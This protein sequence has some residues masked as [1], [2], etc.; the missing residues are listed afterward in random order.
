ML[1]SG[2]FKVQA[3]TDKIQHLVH[4]MVDSSIH[5][6]VVPTKFIPYLWSITSISSINQLY[7]ELFYI[8]N[9]ILNISKHLP[10]QTLT[11]NVP[12][13]GCFLHSPSKETQHGKFWE[14][15]R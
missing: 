11:N 14:E 2:R 15:C 9:Y 5:F 10:M 8:S 6:K 3:K 7:W 12:L 4:F 13:N 1:E